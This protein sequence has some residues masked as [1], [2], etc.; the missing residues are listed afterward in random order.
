MV[1][2]HVLCPTAL[3]MDATHDGPPVTRTSK[4][5][6]ELFPLGTTQ[7]TPLSVQFVE[8]SD[9][10]T[11]GV[12]STCA[13]HS[14]PVHVPPGPV[15]LQMCAIAFGHP[16]AGGL[17]IRPGVAGGTIVAPCYVARVEKIGERLV[18][19]TRVDLFK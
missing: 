8:M 7:E 12:S 13:F 1:S 14:S 16:N 15:E 19:E 2:A 3:T 6:S 11:D 10:T 5:W 17:R 9:K 4:L 18:V